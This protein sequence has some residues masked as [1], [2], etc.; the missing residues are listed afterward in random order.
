[1]PGGTRIV[2]SL[3][4][5]RLDARPAPCESPASVIARVAPAAVLVAHGTADRFFPP[6]EARELFVRANEPKDLWLIRGGGHAEG[7]FSEVAGPVDRTRVDRFVDEV[8]RRTG[9]MMSR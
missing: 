5:V 8:V 4:R 1:M 7:L 3:A 9:R 2:G 6:E